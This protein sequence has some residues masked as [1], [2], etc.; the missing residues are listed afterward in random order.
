MLEALVHLDIELLP[1]DVYQIGFELDDQFI[2]RVFT[3]LRRGW[4]SAPPY[5]SNVQTI[6]DRWISDA[7][8]LIR[9]SVVRTVRDILLHMAKIHSRLRPAIL[10]GDLRAR[11]RLMLKLGL[12]EQESM[13]LFPVTI[14]QQTKVWF[15]ELHKRTP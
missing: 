7:P 1:K 4:D 2:A 15:P 12:A 14:A 11:E 3:L 13:Y 10:K 9:G 5:S 6:G 8:H